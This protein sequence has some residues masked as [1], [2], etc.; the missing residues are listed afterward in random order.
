[1]ASLLF[2]LLVHIRCC[3]LITKRTT[4]SLVT[5]MFYVTKKLTIKRYKVQHFFIHSSSFYTLTDETLNYNT[6]LTHKN[7]Q[8]YSLKKLILLFRIHFSLDE[9]KP[10]Q[11]L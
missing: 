6:K 11:R 8:E 9:R 10:S 7:I 2:E 5:P 1:M 3:H 4:S